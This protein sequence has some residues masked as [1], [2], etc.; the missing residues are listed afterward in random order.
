MPVL[1]ETTP[2]VLEDVP[3]QQYSGCVLELK[4][5]LYD[6]WIAA[7]PTDKAGAAFLPLWHLVEMVAAD[8]D[9]RRNDRG[10]PS[11]VQDVFSC[12]L[13]KVVFDLPVAARV[14]AGPPA[15]R[16]RIGAS[17][18][19]CRAVEV[20]QVGI[21]NRNVIT[22]VEVEPTAGFI[23]SSPVDPQAVKDQMI[24]CRFVI[25]RNQRDDGNFVLRPR[26]F[27]SDQT[28]V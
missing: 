26:D 7:V 18:G 28:V 2:V 9:V 22:A 14:I 4:K 25:N 8:R 20:I 11:S 19:E 17:S 6:K 24:R 12:S 21:D 1:R 16:L 5:V 13:E 23:L 3:F 15:D 27:Q 10:R